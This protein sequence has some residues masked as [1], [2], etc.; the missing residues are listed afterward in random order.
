[1]GRRVAG[2]AVGAVLL[3]ATAQAERL[4]PPPPLGPYAQEYDQL[5]FDSSGNGFVASRDSLFFT[6]SG[7]G[8]WIRIIDATR[9]DYGSVRAIQFVDGHTAFV[10]TDTGL[11]ITGGSAQQLEALT[12]EVPEARAPSGHDVVR[13]GFFFLDRNNG[14]ALGSGQFLRTTDG[15]RTWSSQAIPVRLGDE[16]LQLQ[17]FDA[18]RGVIFAQRGPM[19]TSDGGKS[20]RAPAP[21]PEVDD[22]RC[23]PNGACIGWNELNVAKAHF[24]ADYGE[25]WRET[26]TGLDA[27]KD[28]IYGY[29]ILSAGSAFLVGTREALSMAE[30]ST[31]T[32]GETVVR[33]SPRN[34]LIARWDGARWTAREYPEVEVFFA[35]HHATPTDVWASADTN[36]ILHS[37]DGG[38]T[39]KLVRD[40]YRAQQ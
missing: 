25:T 20:W 14:F 8:S 7:G 18:Q 30:R 34:G 38:Q 27:G 3:G 32:G 33:A 39:W 15:G 35:I 23:L 19:V 40:Y 31:T 6:P 10:Y 1:M 36:G 5:Y 16:P 21:R 4:V 17:M 26:D 24:T 28:S 2:M 11:Y 37:T 9:D 22:G 29:E 12:T 13:S